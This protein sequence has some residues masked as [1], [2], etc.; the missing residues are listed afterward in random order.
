MILLRKPVTLE[1][2]LRRQ[3]MWETVRIYALAGTLALITGYCLWHGWLR[4]AFG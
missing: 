3:R 2:R 4:L 1:Q